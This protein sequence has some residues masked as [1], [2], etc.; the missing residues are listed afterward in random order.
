MPQSRTFAT[1]LLMRTP[2]HKCPWKAA[3]LTLVWSIGLFSTTGLAASSTPTAEL[4]GAVAYLLKQTAES[5]AEFV[6][7]GKTYTATEAVEHMKKKY[8]YF[9]KK[10]EVNTPEDFIRLAATKSLMSGKAYTLRLPDGTEQA[11][12]VWL[13]EKLKQYR[14]RQEGK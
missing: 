14:A 2:H 9:Q 3:I 1:D 8:E 10:G 7:N 6:R 13:G 11:A 5:K 12:A 4:E